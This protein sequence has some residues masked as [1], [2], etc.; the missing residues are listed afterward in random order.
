MLQATLEGT[1]NQLRNI[2]DSCLQ[3]KVA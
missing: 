3:D 1:I 2:N